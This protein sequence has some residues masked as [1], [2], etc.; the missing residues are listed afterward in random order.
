MHCVQLLPSAPQ[1]LSSNPD[2]Q[3]PV[4]SQHPEQLVGPHGCFTGMGVQSV[5]NNAPASAHQKKFSFMA[6][7]LCSA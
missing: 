6:E 2:L 1:K 3:V 4:A 7:D 5:N